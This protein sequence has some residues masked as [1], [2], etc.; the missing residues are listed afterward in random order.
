MNPIILVT[1]GSPGA[2]EA[3][4]IAYQLAQYHQAKL[5]VVYILSEGW[6]SLLGDEWINNSQTRM[7]FFHY[8]EGE[9]HN[10]ANEVLL[11]V[12]QRSQKKGIDIEKEKIIGKYEKVIIEL[13]TQCSMLVLP[14]P[15]GTAHAAAGGLKY[16]P[17]SILKN[18]KC[19]VVIGS[20]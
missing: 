6:G 20:Y 16:S 13:G 1:D 14:N 18:I 4:K 8:F 2:L 9:L 15:Q 10:R 17:S 19:P 11:E 12:E 3:E 7:R 5:K